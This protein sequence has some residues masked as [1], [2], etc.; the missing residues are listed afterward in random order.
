MK[1]NNTQE[2]ITSNDQNLVTIIE[3]KKPKETERIEVYTRPEPSL[4]YELKKTIGVENYSDTN[5]LLYIIII[6][7]GIQK[8]TELYKFITGVLILPKQVA[9]A[10]NFITKEDIILLDRIDDLMHQLM[11]V[12]GA[13]RIAIAKIHNGTYDNTGS[14]QM[15]FSIIY[16]VT[17]RLA[18]T[19]DIV[20][21]IPLN[22]IKEEILLGSW[23]EYQRVERS[24]LDSLCDTF[25][26]KIGIKAKDYK[27]LAVNKIIYG[28]LDIHYIELPLVDFTQNKQ[29]ERRVI[30]ITK[31]IEECLELIILK[32]NWI[33]KIFSKVFKINP[34]F[35]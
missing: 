19:K 3:E 20:Q 8:L 17:D 28:I 24:N 5:F 35:K 26:D 31:E 12:T 4:F 27:L 32:R 1:S 21:N 22:Y 34:V 30:K 10:Y 16:E 18:S 25:L 33:Q 6:I 23:H 13:D 7:F 9:D 2:V 29:L 14:H 11:G 15:K